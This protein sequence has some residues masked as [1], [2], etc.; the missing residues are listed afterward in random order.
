MLMIVGFSVILFGLP[1]VI[2]LGLLGALMFGW[3]LALLFGV[4]GFLLVDL[5]FRRS[6]RAILLGFGIMIPWSLILLIQL[7]DE[8]QLW[9]AL[10]IA[11]VGVL[12]YKRYQARKSQK[13]AHVEGI[14]EKQKKTEPQQVKIT[15]F[16][17]QSMGKPSALRK[18]VGVLLIAGST[19]SFLVILPSLAV[20]DNMHVHI[21]RL[22]LA[23]WFLALV[24]FVGA[25]LFSNRK[26]KLAVQ[27]WIEFVFVTFLPLV[28]LFPLDYE[29]LSICIWI[30]ILASF[31]YW[32]CKKHPAEMRNQAIN[33]T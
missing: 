22:M 33:P 28:V 14:D 4:A 9:L 27:G 30:T 8:L 23:A 3:F 5:G 12:F 32:Y 6:V 19:F 25:S 7:P 2:Q 24:L 31:I 26:L 18:T 11:L 10:F 20:T 15:I 17:Q 16:P 29:I 21:G 1:F 13:I